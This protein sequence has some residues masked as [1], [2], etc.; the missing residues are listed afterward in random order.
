MRLSKSAIRARVKR[1]LPITFSS[2]RISAHGGLELFGRF[3]T[4]ARHRP[5][6]GRGVR[7]TALDGDYGAVRL[8]LAVVGLLVIGGMRVTHLAFVGTD[9]VLLRFCGLHRL[10]GRSHRGALAQA[11][12]VAAARAPCGP[13]PR[14]GA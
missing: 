7:G 5:A 8:L 3:L 12:H 10:P 2:E 1:D 13:D 9:P 14:P 6:R 4:P 11:L